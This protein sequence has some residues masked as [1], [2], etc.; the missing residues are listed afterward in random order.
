M[1]SILSRLTRL[2]ST[3]RVLEARARCQS[4]TDCRFVPSFDTLENRV[5][6]AA[7]V[8]TTFSAATGLLTINADDSAVLAE[9]FQNAEIGVGIPAGALGS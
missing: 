3:Q 7:S 6:P 4:P 2:W 1:K 5:T 8:T 9:Q